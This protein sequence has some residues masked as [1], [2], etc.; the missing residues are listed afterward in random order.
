MNL[1]DVKA[2]PNKRAHKKRV[3]RGN[4]SGW[5]KTAGRGENGQKSR[6]GYSSPRMAEGGQMPIFR[7]IPKKGFTNGP[8]KKEFIIVNV[9]DLEKLEDGTVVTAELLKKTRIISRYKDGVK[10]LGEGELTKKL[11]VKIQKI[12]KS[13]REKIEKTGGTVEIVKLVPKVKK[14]S[15]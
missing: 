12:S 9:A 11:D 6:S 2:S 5:G 3:G 4:G 8:F 1:S 13:A 10:I 7:R 14:V 15:E